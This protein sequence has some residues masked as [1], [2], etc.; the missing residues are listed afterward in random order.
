MKDMVI[1]STLTRLLAN[2]FLFVIVLG[3]SGIVGYQIIQGLTP[4]IWLV[5][6]VGTAIGSSIKILGINAG[7]S[8]IQQ[9]SNKE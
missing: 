6:I 5:G 7:I 2:I 3:A 8:F 9:N 1:N 4:D